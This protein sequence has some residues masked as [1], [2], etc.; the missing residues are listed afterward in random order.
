MKKILLIAQN[1]TKAQEGAALFTGLTVR[2]VYPG[3]KRFPRHFD[4]VVIYHNEPSE[5]NLFKD[6]IEKYSDAPIKVFLGKTAHDQ[7]EHYHA[8]AF[9]HAEVADAVEHLTKEHSGLVELVTKVFTSF[10]KDGS[11]FI[12]RDELKNVAKELGRPLDNAEVEE[13]LKDLDLNSDGRISLDE[14]QKWWLSGR[15]GLSNLMRG[16]LAM[17]LKASKFFTD[18]SSQLSEV[19]LDAANHPV[20]INT[21]S[22]SISLNNVENAGTHLYTKFMVLSNELKEEYN[23]IR[24]IHNFSHDS[25]PFLANLTLAIKDGKAAEAQAT[26]NEAIE[27]YGLNQFLQISVVAEGASNLSI[28]V[29]L[30][31]IPTSIIPLPSEAVDAIQDSLKVNQ[32]VEVSVRLSASPQSL[33]SEGAE[34][35]LKQILSGLQLEV[36]V[37]LWRKI[38]NVLIK[39]IEQGELDASILPIFGGLAPAFLLRLRGSLEI[40]VDEEMQ[41]TL[42]SNPMVEPILM[43]G[44]TLIHALGGCTSD[45]AADYEEHLNSHVPPPLSAVIRVLNQ[46]LGDEISFSVVSDR[47]GVAGRLNGEG[48]GPAIRHASKLFK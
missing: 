38:S 3:T 47:V 18:I 28:G 7:A 5:T 34:P 13:C 11:G 42:F 10:D 2:Q 24:T 15:Q 23:K 45:D 8:R 12:E 26:L 6:E 17:K 44:L 14:F 32:N 21:S 33:L 19:V 37:N 25:R 48:L 36:R 22:I 35:L 1:E 27:M 30:P 20:E 9:T 29:S 41:N 39:V 46:H 4:A 40:D 31:M 16:L 43:D